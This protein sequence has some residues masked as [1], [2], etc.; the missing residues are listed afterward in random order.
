MKIIVV[1]YVNHFKMVS[2]QLDKASAFDLIRT[3]LRNQNI[4]DFNMDELMASI[5]DDSVEGWS[6]GKEGSE[7]GIEFVRVDDFPE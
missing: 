7:N 2:D 3:L 4:L 1:S 5:V 6:A